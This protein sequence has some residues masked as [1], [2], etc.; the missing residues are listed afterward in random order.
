MIVF[1]DRSNQWQD[2][3][4]YI[5]VVWYKN[6]NNGKYDCNNLIKRAFSKA[7]ALDMVEQRNTSYPLKF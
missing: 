5:D 3:C 2:I 7:W 6:P 4:V 1:L